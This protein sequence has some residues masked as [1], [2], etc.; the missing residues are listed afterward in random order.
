M[1][2]KF[3]EELMRLKSRSTFLGECVMVQKES[4]NRSPFLDVL[5][6]AYTSGS[7]FYPVKS[8]SLKKNAANMPKIDQAEAH[9]SK[10]ILR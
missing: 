1:V 10:L 6:C 4:I 7:N 9:T 8:K 2:E 5:I 3:Q